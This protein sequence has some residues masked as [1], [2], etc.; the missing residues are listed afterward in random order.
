MMIKVDKIYT[1]WSTHKRLF[2]KLN[3]HKH[4]LIITH[5]VAPH[6]FSG[7]VQKF[8]RFLISIKHAETPQVYT[9]LSCGTD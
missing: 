2:K 1:A 7:K 6:F 8:L 4:F 5:G 9:R 3:H